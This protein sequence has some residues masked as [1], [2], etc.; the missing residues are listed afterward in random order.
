MSPVLLLLLGGTWRPVNRRC[1]G[2]RRLLCEYVCMHCVCMSVLRSVCVCVMLA[3]GEGWQT[4]WWPLWWCSGGGWF[5]GGWFSGGWLAVECVYVEDDKICV[6][7]SYLVCVLL[8]K[9]KISEYAY[10]VWDDSVVC[11]Y[12]F[13]VC[14]LKTKVM[15][16]MEDE[17]DNVGACVCVYSVWYI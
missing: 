10:V 16:C 5:S 8:R 3:A 11:V 14:M 12:M 2:Y 7:V 13:D 15:V 6:C 1:C 17:E 9:M 4:R